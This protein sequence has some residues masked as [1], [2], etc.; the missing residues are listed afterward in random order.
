M[1]F[2]YYR[3]DSVQ[4]VHKSHISHRVNEN[5]D[6]STGRSSKNRTHDRW[7]LLEKP[8]SIFNKSDNNGKRTKAIPH[9]LHATLSDL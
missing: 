1:R 7:F 9:P 8:Y 5:D 3:T 6:V 4:M 2:L